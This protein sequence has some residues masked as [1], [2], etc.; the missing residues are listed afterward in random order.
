MNRVCIFLSAVVIGSCLVTPVS[1]QH[2][3]KRL[4]LELATGGEPERLALL[5]VYVRGILAGLE[6]TDMQLRREG[7]NRLA[8]VPLDPP[9]DEDWAINELIDYFRSYPGIPDNSSLALN[10]QL[11]LAEQFACETSM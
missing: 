8:C 11:M 4:F 1:A 9:L 10:I 2:M 3:D 6:A 5:K 7:R